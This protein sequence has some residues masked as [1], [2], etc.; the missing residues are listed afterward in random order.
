MRYRGGEGGQPASPLVLEVPA[1]RSNR[2][3]GQVLRTHECASKVQAAQTLELVGHGPDKALAVID[4]Q[5]FELRRIFDIGILD[6]SAVE[7]HERLDAVAVERQVHEHRAS[8]DVEML[9]GGGDAIVRY[10]SLPLSLCTFI[11]VALL[12]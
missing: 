11:V 6:E 12:Y 8:V 7:Q 1:A 3:R 4:E 9:C 10:L 2:V 5:A